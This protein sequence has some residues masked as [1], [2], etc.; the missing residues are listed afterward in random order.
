MNREIVIDGHSILIENIDQHKAG[1]HINDAS[2]IVKAIN[3][4]SEQIVEA[5]KPA[6]AILKS[7]CDSAQE[8]M[9]DEMELSMQFELSLN[10]EVPVFKIV[11]ADATA[12]IAVKFVWKK[13]E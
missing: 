4:S 6:V 5:T 8:M 10:G 11:S 13:E 3:W 7:L 9:P 2:G 12:Q 1:T